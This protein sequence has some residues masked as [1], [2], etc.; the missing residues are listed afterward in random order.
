MKEIK[1]IKVLLRTT[2]IRVIAYLWRVQGVQ[3]SPGAH[4]HF[5]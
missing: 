5:P 1:T 4:S 2:C 3:Q